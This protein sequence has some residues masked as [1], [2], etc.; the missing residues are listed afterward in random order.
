MRY[1]DIYRA[2]RRAIGGN[3]RAIYPGQVLLIP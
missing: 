2:N 1:L 3:P